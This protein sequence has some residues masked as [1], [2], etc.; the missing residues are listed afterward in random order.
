MKPRSWKPNVTV[1]AVIERDGRFLLV[2][3]HTPQGLQLNQPAGHLEEG[4][5]LLEATVRETLEETAHDFVPDYLV[6]IYQWPTPARDITYLRFAFGGRLGEEIAG[7]RL[8]DG[9]VRALWLTP[10]EVRASTARHRSP[11]ILQ[12]VEDWLSGRR[13][14][15]ALIR[16]YA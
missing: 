10:G 9:I 16:H 14:P 15:L 11:L 5:S 1:A 13:Y 2:E 6:G 3:E 8:D 4:E 7:R 12:C